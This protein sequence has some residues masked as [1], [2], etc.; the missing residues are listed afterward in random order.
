MKTIQL[1][2]PTIKCEGCVETLRTAL[3]KRSGVQ[4]VAGDPNRKEVTVRFNPDQLT[5]HEIRAAI[6]DAGFLVG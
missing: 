5:E 1:K 4:T 2:V 3:S 6:A